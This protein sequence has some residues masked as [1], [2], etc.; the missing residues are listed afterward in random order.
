MNVTD[1]NDPT[2]QKKNP[3][4]GYSGPGAMT[5]ATGGSLGYTGPQATTNMTGGALGDIG[6]APATT[7]AP[8]GTPGYTGPQ[9]TTGPVGLPTATTGPVG[10]PPA[11]TGPVG[12]PTAT[13]GPVGP[14]PAAAP[15][16]P[17]THP[18]FSWGVVGHGKEGVDFGN[19][20][21]WGT[22]QWTQ[23][24]HDHPEDPWSAQF[25][26]ASTPTA[27]SAPTPATTTPAATTN[28]PSL[29]DTFQQALIARLTPQTASAS[30]PVIRGSIDANNLA[31]QRSFERARALAAEDQAR[32]GAQGA[33]S[34]DFNTQLLGLNADRGAQEAQFAGNAVQQ[35]QQMYNQNATSALGTAGGY[36]TA[37]QQQALQRELANQSADIQRQSIA[38]QGSLGQGDLSL[39]RDLGNQS[40]NLSLLGLLMNNDQFGRQLGQ[41]AS[42]FGQSL[43]QSGLLSLL[44]LI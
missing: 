34:G 31:Q 2:Q 3:A 40:A 42:Q 12:P 16:A 24:A 1:P 26:G 21:T 15:A 9:A 32:G 10:P 6:G 33:G 4:L 19:T 14:P 43:D 20:N 22:A 44:G 39:R 8:G 18:N 17:P 25:L 41:N 27:P 30:D 28:T 5:E 38:Q 37:Q 36:L 13:T 29:P 7:N 23:Y 35:L 11:T